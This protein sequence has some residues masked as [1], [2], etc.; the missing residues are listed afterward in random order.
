MKL[1]K[2]VAGIL[3]AVVGVATVLVGSVSQASAAT[4]DYLY[5]GQGD[6]DSIGT[7]GRVK[8]NGTG[9]NIGLINTST[10]PFAVAVTST[11][12][13]WIPGHSTSIARSNLDGTGL[14]RN[15]IRNVVK[16]EEN[17]GIAVS[18]THIY[19][20]NASG[21]IGRAKIDGTGANNS[22]MT[23]APPVRAMAISSS[24]IYW[25]LGDGKIGRANIN[26]TGINN[27]FISN[28]CSPHGIT[29]SSS[30]VYWACI[31]T[32]GIGRAN[33][34]GSGA[35]N[36]WVDPQLPTTDVAVTG[37]HVYWSRVDGKIGRANING[38]GAN[39]SFVTG[40]PGVVTAL[41]VAAEPSSKPSKVQRLTVSG[42]SASTV[43]RFKWKA[44][45]AASSQSLTGYKLTIRQ[46]GK[47]KVL[48]TK[49][50][51]NSQLKTSVKRSTIL[52]ALRAKQRLRGEYGGARAFVVTVRAKNASGQG[53][54]TSKTFLIKV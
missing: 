10:M 11:H 46:R 51:K 52:R 34:N 42:G 28:I 44:P 23:V 53:A 38:S 26:G 45:K 35:N 49:N 31:A 54:A 37:S 16:H 3:A 32:N 5:F 9:K 30:H 33:I 47:K 1:K 6:D 24:H 43:F 21:K 8:Q 17:W 27:S 25:A 20:A 7:I 18:G 19:W 22:F 41:A 29:V 36:T 2:F 12:L 15:F 50:L 48:V 13:Y 39:Q 40:I 4:N 14:N